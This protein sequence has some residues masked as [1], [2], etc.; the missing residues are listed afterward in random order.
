MAPAVTTASPSGSGLAAR[1]KQMP[2]RSVVTC[3]RT[4]SAMTRK[5]SR[6]L[7]RLPIPGVRLGYMIAH[8][9]VINLF[10][11]G[12]LPWRLNC[13]ADAVAAALPGHGQD[14]ERIRRLNAARREAFANDLRA[15]GI[16]VYPSEA[17]F[18][19][20]DFGC[21]VR[22]LEDALKEKKILVRRCMNFPGIDDGRHLR[23][24]VKDAK[25][26]IYKAYTVAK[27]I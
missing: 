14:F 1:E 23:L 12:L 5:N 26:A 15:L 17:N 18:L 9:H 24:A 22:P 6:A 20:C 19:L 25:W 27:S 16:K 8:P 10:Y 13:V 11:N 3:S 21:Q 2:M 7:I 4:P